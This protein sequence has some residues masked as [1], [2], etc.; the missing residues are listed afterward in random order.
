M[1]SVE[2]IGKEISSPFSTGGGGAQFEAH[3][4][5]SFVV[6][7]LADGFVPCLSALPIKKIKFQ[8]K[9]DG[10]QTDDVIIF[11]EKPD[12]GQKQKLMGQ[13]KHSVS[14]TASDTI[15]CDVINAAWKDFN[16]NTVF[17]K[18]QD[19]IALITGPLSGTDIDGARWILEWARSCETAE[20]FVRYVGTAKFSSDNK[21]DKLAAFRTQLAKANSG[22]E[23]S[24]DQLFEFL[25]HFHILSYDLD[26]KS[27]VVLSL[28]HSL[29]N[30]YHMDNVRAIWAQVVDEVQTANK[31]AGTLTRESL[32]HD[33]EVA[34]Q[35]Q[36]YATI[37]EA[38][39][40]A[41]PA[42]LDLNQLPHAST[43]ALANLVG[44]WDENC[45]Q[46]CAAIGKL[47]GEQFS[48]WIAKLQ[49]VLQITNS[50][51]TL[52][53]GEWR[54]TERTSVWQSL[55]QRI[56]DR[57]LDAFKAG[58]TLILSERDPKFDLP[59]GERFGATLRGKTLSHSRAV[60]KGLAETLA[61]MGANPKALANCSDGK[62][63]TVAILSL[64]EVFKDADW[65][66]WGS[67]NDLLPLLAEAAPEEFL[68]IVERDLGQDLSPFD[69]LFRQEGNGVTGENYLTGLL[70]AL[71]SLAWDEQH[72]VQVCVLL[73][74]LAA[75]DPGGHSGNRPINS[76]IT[77]LL[78]WL[79]QTEAS[80]DKRT[81]AIQTIVKEQPEVAWNLLLSLLP[82]PHQMSAQSHRPTF[83]SVAPSAVNKKVTT[84]EYWKQVSFY[85]DTVM[86]LAGED[87]MKLAEI[88]A[89]LD[90][91]PFEKIAAFAEK[92][93]SVQLETKPV[94]ETIKLWTKLTV[95]IARQ[96]QLAERQ[97]VDLPLAITALS[98]IAKAIEPRN[99]AHHYRKLFGHHDP[100]FYQ[101]SDANWDQRGKKQQERR[102]LAVREILKYGGLTSILEFVEIADEP[103][104]VGST[105]GSIAEDDMDSH[106]LPENL[107]SENRRILEFLQDYV[108]ARFHAQGWQWLQRLSM[109]EWSHTDIGRFFA[110]LPF[111]SET[112]NRVKELPADSDKE[113]WAHVNPNPYEAT[114]DLEFAIDKLI[115]SDRPILALA[116]L[117]RA[118][119]DHHPLNV[120]QAERA[121]LALLRS[122]EFSKAADRHDIMNVLKA[123]QEAPTAEPDVVGQIEWQL[124][125]LL[126]RDFGVE[127]KMLERRLASDPRFF[128]EVIRLLYRSEREPKESREPTPQELS[129][130]KNAWTLLHDW[131]LAPGITPEGS[132]SSEHFNRWLKEIREVCTESGHLS[133]A[134]SHVGC[135]LFYSPAD[136]DGLWIHRTIAQAL[137]EK[138]AEKLR[139]GFGQQIFNSRGVHWVDPSGQQERELSEQ[140][141][142]KAED[143]ENA[144]FQRLAASLR[145]IA[146]AYAREAEHVIE[147]ARANK[148]DDDWN[149]E[150]GH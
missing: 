60:R 140:Y 65:V 122:S 23:V 105:L 117:N 104:F 95:F 4:H 51:I 71:E 126:D 55:G 24:E 109:A 110:L 90:R 59:P 38:Y 7:M 111:S 93:A 98:E 49:E 145:A 97:S 21:R 36:V 79:P 128:C 78:P 82:K 20:E 69:E 3:V 47:V 89:A 137:N 61:L 27:G 54:V 135:V 56:F 94:D 41:E 124:L 74:E 86:Q 58:A 66:K 134:L 100:E 42:R 62:V 114:A 53:N 46:D 77:I 116:C 120:R 113:Y 44:A 129:I 29:M 75:R 30:Q 136:P 147:E 63:R 70:W 33:L 83:R 14:F 12:G 130:A 101:G 87:V 99:P 142:A 138:D 123:L 107:T 103:F 143:V 52:R 57:S 125:P 112:W 133:V 92:L 35:R 88:A 67:L 40:P 5:A 50:P 2:A 6:L 19:A 43:I 48:N 26:V 1:N 13:I 118:I 32:P 37:P 68:C 132:L 73:S 15:F 106:F 64:R 85:V 139:S 80:T 18:R 148:L 150:E 45:A 17:T 11:M 149:D 16:N 131:R 146:D 127:P 39:A 119:H 84:E 102:R 28:L 31:N 22:N 144:G 72:F 8:G 141:R 96:Q 91:L 25:R 10:H 121:L 108:R 115:D 9:I 81:I 34:F 76:L